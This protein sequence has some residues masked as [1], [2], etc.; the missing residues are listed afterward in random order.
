MI[1]LN[2]KTV[3]CII[4]KFFG[5]DTD[6]IEEFRRRGATVD[7]L[8]DRPFT[9]PFMTAVTRFGRRLVLPHS[10]RLY[11]EQLNDYGRSG[12]DYIFVVNGLTVSRAFLKSLISAYPAAKRILY[13]WDSFHSRPSALGVIDLYD[14]VLTFDHGDSEAYGLRHR[15]LFF[16]HGF[17]QAST[18]DFDHHISF[19]GTAHTDRAPIVAGIDSQ[20]PDW[21]NRYW[22]LFLQAP[23][24]ATS[25]RLLNPGFRKVPNSLLNF[26]PLPREKVQRVFARSFSI[27]DI[28]HPRQS[29]LTMRTFEALGSSKKMVTTNPDIANYDF[30]DSRNICIIDRKKPEI[31]EDFFRSPYTPPDPAIYRRHSISG[32]LDEILDQVR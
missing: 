31:P 11:R 4:S 20:L 24:V 15:P 27:L 29:G 23:W 14:E 30:F 9:S 12:Y 25:Y 13:M 19:I 10:D 21:V 17:E 28:Q 16:S 1:D 7:T 2:N 26:A 22:Y 18:P 6:I 32:W 3:L 8:T 5:Y